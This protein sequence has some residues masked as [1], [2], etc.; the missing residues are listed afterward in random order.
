MKIKVV[1]FSIW[2]VVKRDNVTHVQ[3][4]GDACAL[5]RQHF[6]RVM[7]RS[8]FHVRSSCKTHIHVGHA[9]TL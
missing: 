4:K 1:A 8:H 5:Q 7:P 2:A 9:A 3:C 6:C